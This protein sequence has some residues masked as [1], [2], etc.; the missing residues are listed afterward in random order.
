MSKQTNPSAWPTPEHPAKATIGGT[1]YGTLGITWEEFP[2]MERRGGYSGP[3]TTE[4]EA[5]ECV[6][7]WR[8]L[9]EIPEEAVTVEVV[10][11]LPQAQRTSGAE[12]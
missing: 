11:L 8:E 4:E 2:A 12:L 1:G 10:E 9:W 7:R 3:F 6:V 5:R